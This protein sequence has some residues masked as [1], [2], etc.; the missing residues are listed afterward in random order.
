[1]STV[2]FL[3]RNFRDRRH[4]REGSLLGRE[5]RQAAKGEQKT[6]ESASFETRFSMGGRKLVQRNEFQT[7]M[8]AFGIFDVSVA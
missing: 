2:T 3:S 4:K 8:K 5:R 1:M 7:Q 6:Q